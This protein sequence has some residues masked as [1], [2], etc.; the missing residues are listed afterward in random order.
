VTYDDARALEL[1]AAAPLELGDVIARPAVAIGALRTAPVE[2]S[3]T[4][5]GL[6]LALLAGV[7]GLPDEL[8]GTVDVR[9]TLTGSVATPRGDLTASVAH[10]AIAGYRDVGLE[11]GVALEASQVSV[12]GQLGL[13]TDH[14]LQLDG[15]IAAPVEQLLAADRLRTTPLRIDGV[16]PRVELSRGAGADVTVPLAGVIEG[17]LSASGTLAAPVMQVDLEGSG[18][19][20]NG[21]PLGDVTLRARHASARTEAQVAIRAMAGGK[22]DVTGTLD[23]PLGVGVRRP[24]LREAPLDARLVASALDLGVLPALLPGIVRAASGT[25]TANVT[26]RGPLARPRPRG[27][28]LLDGQRVAIAQYGEWTDVALDVEVNDDALELRRLIARRGR[29]KLEAS[30]L[31]R[32]LAEPSSPAEL[33]VTA[34]SLGINRAGQELAKLDLRVDASGT[35]TADALRVEVRIGR[36]AA[37]ALR[38]PRSSSRSSSGRTSWSGGARAA[39][40]ASAQRATGPRR[41][42]SALPR[43]RSRSPCTS[44]RPGSSSSRATAR[45][46]TS[47]SRRTC[48]TSSA[49]AA[50]TRRETYPWCEASWSRSAAA[51][52]TSNAGAC[53]SPA[54]RRRRRCSTSRRPTR[55]RRRRSP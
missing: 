1:K 54:A 48:R 36:H 41:R 29:G 30:G 17:R 32:N 14:V 27:K 15:A 11:I 19:T 24:P 50:T 4:V 39:S 34:E 25:I 53:S 37:A 16:V 12:S 40:G 8:R 13:G 5:P 49:A 28:V 3:A 55:T 31:V 47:S 35:Y 21:R 42:R 43:N 22:V 23:A 44:S 46:S 33:H 51:T 52:S 45:G 26:A 9:A 20:V 7:L 10:G 6:D 2:A 18:I 38:T